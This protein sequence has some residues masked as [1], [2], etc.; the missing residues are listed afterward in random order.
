MARGACMVYNR[1]MA[2]SGKEVAKNMQAL[3]R[4]MGMRG[5]IKPGDL[6]LKARQIMATPPKKKASVSHTLPPLHTKK[7]VAVR[8]LI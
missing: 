6:T 7:G 8:G 4:A 2:T 5:E 3:K 1:C